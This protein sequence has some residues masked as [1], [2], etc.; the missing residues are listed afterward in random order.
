MQRARAKTCKKAK[1]DTT[2]DNEPSEDNN[3]SQSEFRGSSKSNL[4][5]RCQ[6]EVSSLRTS[7]GQKKGLRWVNKVMKAS[8]NMIMSNNKFTRSQN[9][10]VPN[11]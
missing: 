11:L 1:I 5:L 7:G 9:K 4:F 3:S 8:K 6:E 2:K 10:E